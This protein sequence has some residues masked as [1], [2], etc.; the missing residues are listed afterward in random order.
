[1][2]KKTLL[3][4]AL[5]LSVMSST[6]AAGIYFNPTTKTAIRGGFVS[7]DVATQVSASD[8]SLLAIE[9]TVPVNTARFKI[10][11]A[12]SLQGSNATCSYQASTGL[13]ISYLNNSGN[14]PLAIGTQSVCR[15]SL[16]VRTTTPVGTYFLPFNNA[17]AF[18]WSG[19]TVPLWVMSGSI[20]VL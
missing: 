20:K 3:T 11:G 18:D 6:Y 12:T 17:S 10:I 4:L 9:A 2:S 1:M 19:N 13:T 7:M 5:G 16:M 14:S 8:P 15:L